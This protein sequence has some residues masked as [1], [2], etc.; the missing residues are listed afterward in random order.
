M[1]YFFFGASAIAQKTPTADIAAEMGKSSDAADN[2][3][4]SPNDLAKFLGDPSKGVYM[5]TEKPHGDAG[6]HQ[7]LFS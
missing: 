4:K 6:S 2:S 1:T 5:H 7:S 3:I